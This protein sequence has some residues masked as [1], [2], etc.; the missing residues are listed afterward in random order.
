MILASG[1]L[2]DERRAHSTL[3]DTWTVAN[4]QFLE[5]QRLLM[6]DL[7]R[8]ESLLTTEQ[9]KQLEGS[10][11]RHLPCSF[12]RHFSVFYQLYSAS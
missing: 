9:Q 11:I 8:I 10:F 5:A 7:N 1:E 4:D 3:R 2:T 12:I 6:N